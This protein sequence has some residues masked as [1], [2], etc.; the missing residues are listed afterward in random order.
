MGKK[1][2]CFFQTPKTGKRNPNS[3]VKGSGVNHYPRAAPG[4]DIDK[5]LDPVLFF[6]RETT[7]LFEFVERR[8]FSISAEQVS[9]CNRFR[10]GTKRLKRGA[11]TTTLAR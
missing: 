5:A 8:Y 11:L 7:N 4:T 2:F 6:I 1:H 3:S 10:K 9:Q